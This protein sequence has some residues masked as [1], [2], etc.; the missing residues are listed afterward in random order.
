MGLNLADTIKVGEGTY[1][2][3]YLWKGDHSF[4]VK[5]HAVEFDE[6]FEIDALRCLMG[7][8]S[9]VLMLECGR[10]GC[11]KYWIR[12]PRYHMDLFKYLTS[13]E[14][15]LSREDKLAILSRVASGLS[16]VH[17]KGWLHRDIKLD[18][19]LVDD[20][21]HVV[22]ADFGMAVRNV[23]NRLMS[24]PVFARK[25]RAPELCTD[26]NLV[27]ST[28]VDVFAFGVVMF[29]VLTGAVVGGFDIQERNTKE[30]MIVCNILSRTRELEWVGRE[31][32]S[33]LGTSIGESKKRPKMEEFHKQLG[34]LSCENKDGKQENE[35]RDGEG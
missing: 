35:R 29:E 13:N 28:E 4:V 25:Y 32:V 11:G 16:Y 22:L 17:E 18:N 7:H 19:I 34:F 5:H 33:L 10:L 31:M 9:V 27:Y 21:T 3:V 12:F 24:I 14:G 2:S 20:P 6:T 1:A 8:P 15:G 26:K 30:N 23:P